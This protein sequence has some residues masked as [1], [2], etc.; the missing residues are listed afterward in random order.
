MSDTRDKA[1]R[2]I[3]DSQLNWDQ[4]YWEAISPEEW[5][6]EFHAAWARSSGAHGELSQKQQINF[7][8]VVHQQ[9]AGE[10]DKS[11]IVVMQINS[12]LRVPNII[13]IGQHLY[14]L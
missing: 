12:V 10:V 4:G 13:E 9:N 14:K 3:F 5:I 7:P 8:E 1:S 2:P 6:S 11:T